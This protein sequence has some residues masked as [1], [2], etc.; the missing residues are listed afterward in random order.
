MNCLVILVVTSWLGAWSN[1]SFTTLSCIHSSSTALDTDIRDE[2]YN[3]C[4]NVLFVSVPM[5][6]TRSRNERERL[7]SGGAQWMT[8]SGGQSSGRGVDRAYETH[9]NEGGYIPTLTNV[10]EE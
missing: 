2:E 4:C 8:A 6:R 7:G 9:Y 5:V 1:H 10:G 3:D